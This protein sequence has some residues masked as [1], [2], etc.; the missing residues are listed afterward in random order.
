LPPPPA[1]ERPGLN[2]IKVPQAAFMSTDPKSTKKTI[3][4]LVFFALLG[5]AR[6]KA[7]CIMLMKLTPRGKGAE[8]FQKSVTY[9]LNGLYVKMTVN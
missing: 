2:F 6:A 8:K 9:Y 7:A 3:K 5:S 1:H 4:L